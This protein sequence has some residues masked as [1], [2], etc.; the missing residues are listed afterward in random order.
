MP[1]HLL[2][3]PAD[4]GR[5]LLALVVL[6][7]QIRVTPLREPVEIEVA[8]ES[9][10][11]RDGERGVRDTFVVAGDP[12]LELGRPVAAAADEDRRGRRAAP[13]ARR[14]R[15]RADVL[16]AAPWAARDPHLERLLARRRERTRPIDTA[17]NGR[18]DG[19]IGKGWAK[20]LRATTDARVARSAAAHRG[21]T[22]TRR[23]PLEMGRWHRPPLIGIGWTDAMAYAVGLLATDGCL[24]TG[25]KRIQFGSEDRDLVELLLACLGR[26]ATIRE[27][28]TRTGSLYYRAQFG[29]ARF[30]EWLLS[31]GLT[32]RKSLTIGAIPVPSEHLIALA[33]GLMDGDGSIGNRFYRADTRGRAGYMWEYLWVAFNSSS[34]SHLDWLRD[35]LGVALGLKGYLGRTERPGRAPHFSLRYGKRASTILLSRMYADDEAPALV[36]KRAIWKDYERR[37][38]ARDEGA[39]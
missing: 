15:I 6:E 25:L 32:P 12:V 3:R 33:R 4:P 28:P 17:A 16:G 21:L 27:Q 10:T 36:R 8:Q 37:H 39:S 18:L 35:Q 31:I 7:E 11:L 29:D 30:Y 5:T 26:P 9:E 20:G 2:E 19:P 22:Y 14:M 23:Q 13:H 38:L 34:R 24:V 1:V